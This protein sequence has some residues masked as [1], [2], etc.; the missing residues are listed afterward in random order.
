MVKPH[1]CL[2]LLRGRFVSQAAG[3][4]RQGQHGGERPRPTLRLGDELPSSNLR[5]APQVMQNGQVAATFQ[6]G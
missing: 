2:V 5:S 6:Q 3:Q 1:Q 4:R